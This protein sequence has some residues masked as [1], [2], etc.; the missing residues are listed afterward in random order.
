MIQVTSVSSTLW[1]YAAVPVV[2]VRPLSYASYKFYPFL[3]VPKKNFDT[4]FSSRRDIRD[5]LST[6]PFSLTLT[7]TWMMDIVG[8]SFGLPGHVLLFYT[9]SVDSINRLSVLLS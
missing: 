1:R 6:H 9:V 2:V 4:G 7:L 5:L 8:Q 3:I